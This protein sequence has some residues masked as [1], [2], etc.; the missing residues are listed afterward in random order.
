[1]IDSVMI[2]YLFIN[3][4]FIRPVL[5]CYSCCSIKRRDETQ[6]SSLVFVLLLFWCIIF[7]KMSVMN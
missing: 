5:F 3:R 2:A 4:I 6:Y 7:H 1:M